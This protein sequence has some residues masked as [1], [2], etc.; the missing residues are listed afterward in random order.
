MSNL[1]LFFFPGLQAVLTAGLALAGASVLA[2]S[3]PARPVEPLGEITVTATLRAEALTKVPASVTVLDRQTIADAG[4]QHFQ[5]VLGLVPNLN[6]AA[7]S[8]R[9]RYFQLRGVGD[10]EQYQGAPNPSIG[11]LVDDI[12]FSGV[13]MAATL[14][15]VEQVEVLRGPQGTSYGANA[16]GGLIKVRT[17]EPQRTLEAVT[18]VSAGQDDEWSVGAVLGGAIP[19]TESGAFRLGVQEYQS[20]GFRRNAFLGRDDTNGRDELTARGRVRFQPSERW[21]IDVSALAIDLDNG[22]DAFAI[23][24]SRV[25]QSD[26]PG[27]DSQRSLGGSLDLRYHADA[28]EVVSVS[29]Y[30][31]S[32]IDYGFDGDW[33]NDAFWGVPYDYTSRILRDR[34]TLTQDLRIESPGIGAG[35]TLAWIAGA[36]VRQLDESN[37]QHDHGLYLTDVSAAVVAER[38]HLQELRFVRPGG[39]GLRARLRAVAG[40]ACGAVRRQLRG[41]EWGAICTER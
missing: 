13:G 7:G 34:R 3:A 4:E 35:R 14:F 5:D 16:L 19:G 39:V 31:D 24:N 17:R 10:L 11:F 37:D 26:H 40:A 20:D 23:D 38:L 32:E 1:R 8:S 41:L 2:Q 18:E 9:P 6:W 36:Y 30:A 15:D 33:G 28:F 21:Q 29:A 12:D 27:S 25:T 22:Y